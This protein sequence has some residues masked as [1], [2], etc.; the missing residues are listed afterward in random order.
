MDE[1]MNQILIGIDG[2]E[3]NVANRVGS[4]QYAYHILKA[5]HALE[6]KHA[7]RIYLKS[8]PLPDMPKANAN[9]RYRVIKPQKLWTQARLPADL[10]VHRPKPHIF[11]SPGHYAPRKSPVPTVVSIMDLAFLH[12][13]N[14]FLKHK[15]GTAQLEQW[16]AYSVK[17]STKVIAISEHTRQ[18]VIA[19]YQK[20]PADVIVAYPGVDLKNFTKPSELTKRKLAKK[21][22]LK[23][24]F[25]LFVGTIQPR[26]NLVRLLEAFSSLPPSF[27]E[28]DLVLAGQRG[29]LTEEF[30]H[31]LAFSKAKN[32]IKLLGFVPDSEVP[33]LYA[34]AKCSVLIGLHEGFGMPAAESFASGTLPVVSN[35][36]S[37]PEVVGR[38]GILVDPY[39]V[40]SIRHGLKRALELDDISRA[41]RIALGQEHI[42]K[43]DWHVS[44]GIIL[45][46]LEEIVHNHTKQ[47]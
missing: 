24:P 22:Q 28:F 20:N 38:A 25:A 12:Y 30:D 42:K 44:A 45:N 7:F 47:A 2:N 4:N 6:S 16:S 36:S 10:F 26:K 21:Y 23:K 9:W 31:A 41:K 29:W 34:M 37:L 46:T 17:Q 43:F 19:S 39:S 11:F 5:L 15:R 14:L 40:T 1:Y 3:A 8:D 27:K 33:V 35:N 32:R 18:D 13:P